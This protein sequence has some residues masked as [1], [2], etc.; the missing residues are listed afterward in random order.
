VRQL[1]A[2]TDGSRPRAKEVV[3]ADE[4]YTVY[5]KPAAERALRKITAIDRARIAKAI[6][7]LKTNPRPA[8][9]KALQG[10]PGALRIRVGDYRIIYTVNDDVLTVLVVTIGHR[11]DVY[12]RG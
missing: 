1:P 5:L 12:K 11:R 4:Q 10:M 8:G 6:D 7:H 3:A 2:G 9:A